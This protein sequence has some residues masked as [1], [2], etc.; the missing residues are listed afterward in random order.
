MATPATPP[1]SQPSAPFPQPP[2]RRSGWT[3]KAWHL[4]ALAL[5]FG[6]GVWVTALT[7]S[8]L[9][10]PTPEE[11]TVASDASVESEHHLVWVGDRLAPL[12][13]VGNVA[14]TAQG[15][16]FADDAGLSGP[17]TALNQL[18]VAAGDFSLEV[19]LT[20]AMPE[21]RGQGRILTLARSVA[22]RNL[23]L[24]QS[25]SALEM[26]LRTTATEPTGL[27]PHLVTGP[28]VVTGR[29]QAVMF[30]RQ[31]GRHLLYVDGALVASATVPGDLS[32]WDPG[33]ELCLGQD[34]DGGAS[35][36]GTL[37]L[38][39][40]I[41]RALTPAEVAARAGAAAGAH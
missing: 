34:P 8:W 40:V 2:A 41:S 25:G 5:V 9:A 28:G 37:H 3:P 24:S 35:W 20:A 19:E 33:C 14:I 12:H 38:L 27:R 17:A 10:S 36:R 6:S 7:L 26:R 4:A 29:R 39:T 21:R 16:T 18:L 1:S 32:T 11:P 30:V 23:A 15:V 31:Q 13:Q 22:V